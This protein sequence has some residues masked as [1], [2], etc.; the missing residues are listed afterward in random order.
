MDPQ[1]FDE[2]TKSIGAGPTSRRRVVGGLV[3]VA[4]GAALARLKPTDAAALNRPCK[5]FGERCNKD[6]ACCAGKCSPEH[7]CH[8]RHDQ[9]RCQIPN[10][11]VDTCCPGTDPDCC[12][13]ANHAR[14]QKP[15]KTKPITVCCPSTDPTCCQAP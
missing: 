11:G 13:G 15:G 8:C 10:R 12:C 3:A 14:C 7:V 6:E 5:G 9:A 2:L 4:L 1:R